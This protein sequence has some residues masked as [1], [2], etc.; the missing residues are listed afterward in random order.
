[1]LPRLRRAAT[2]NATE[3]RALGCVYCYVRGI[4]IIPGRVVLYE[5][6]P[7]PVAAELDRKR[8][9]PKRVYFVSV[10]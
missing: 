6:L 3:G 9:R 7:E 1:M 2:V 4:R 5:N 8:R 10:Q